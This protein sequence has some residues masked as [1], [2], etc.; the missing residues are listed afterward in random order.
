MNTVLG[1]RKSSLHYSI[2]ERRARDSG[3][4]SLRTNVVLGWPKNPY[5]VFSVK[6]DT[7]FILADNFIDLGF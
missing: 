1:R 7:F 3:A 6:Y 4:V 5:G 2:N